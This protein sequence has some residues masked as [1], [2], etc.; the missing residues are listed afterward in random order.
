MGSSHVPSSRRR[1]ASGS[2]GWEAPPPR[3]AD[4]LPPASADRTPP[5]EA[6]AST[7]PPEVPAPSDR[8][9]RPAPP[10]R[11][12]GRPP[13]RTGQQARTPSEPALTAAALRAALSTPEAARRAI[14][15]REVLG[16]PVSL[17][18]PLGRRPGGW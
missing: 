6:V 10:P 5:P 9:R 2:A 4:R 3:P 7:P 11:G 18:G 1:T 15:L 16:P 13:A 14:V 12:A 17:Q 8:P